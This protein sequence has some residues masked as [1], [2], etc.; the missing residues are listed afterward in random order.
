MPGCH[1]QTQSGHRTAP[2][3]H[4]WA[5]LVLPSQGTWAGQAPSALLA[6]LP[7][8]APHAHHL[9]SRRA[10]E[11]AAGASP[12]QRS[13]ADTPGP[14][15]PGPRGSTSPHPRHLPRLLRPRATLLL[16]AANPHRRSSP[17]LPGRS[18]GSFFNS[19]PS[20]VAEPL[21]AASAR[22]SPA[23]YSPGS[24][25]LKLPGRPSAEL[26]LAQPVPAAAPAACSEPW[27]PR[28]GAQAPA[29]RLVRH[30][31]PARRCPTCAC[32]AGEPLASAVHVRR[33]AGSAASARG[34][35]FSLARGILGIA[36]C[37]RW[38]PAPSTRGILGVVV[39]SRRSAVALRVVQW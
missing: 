19:K 23:P 3:G 38:L 1:H 8:P 31:R 2:R 17:P 37:I 5:V 21:P 34:R 13:V 4:L 14:A 20:R 15:V 11:P 10:W 12:E 6:W 32:P 33:L 35:T 24:T 22:T 7:P 27:R 9:P 25:G 16:P 18:Q 39:C 26:A 29:R 30:R 36:V 28:K